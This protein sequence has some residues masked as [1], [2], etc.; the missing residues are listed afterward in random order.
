MSAQRSR[1]T[2][3]YPVLAAV[4]L[5]LFGC[6]ISAA[7]IY[8]QFQGL[9]GALG[10]MSLNNL[11]QV[12]VPGSREIRFSKKGTYAVYYEYRSV[13]NNVSYISNKTP[14]RLECNLRSKTSGESASLAPDYV[15]SN[16]YSTKNNERV[17]VLM[18]SISID[19]PGA[20]DFSCRYPDGSTMPKVVLAV[21]P[22]FMW[23]FFSVAAR[24]LAAALGGLVVFGG[25]SA[26]SVILLLV[27][28]IVRK[29]RKPALS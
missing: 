24:P 15:E 4:L 28:Y 29:S 23:E 14:P 21:G 26:I 10:R 20:Y 27:T 25:L 19:Q 1:P 6:L 5:P 16:I 7:I 2:R 17:G 22:N 18:M 11:T 9:P 8:G 13:V 3:W 12:V